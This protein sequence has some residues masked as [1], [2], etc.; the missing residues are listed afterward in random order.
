SHER[1]RD[2][3]GNR[4]YDGERGER[5]GSPVPDVR[6]Q[7]DEREVVE[8][9]PE[10]RDEL[11]GEEQPEGP[12]TQRCDHGVA[13]WSGIRSRI[14]SNTPISPSIVC[15]ALT[16]RSVSCSGPSGSRSSVSRNSSRWWMSSI[17]WRAS[18]RN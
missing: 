4:D 2:G 13:A 1:R 18:E 10:V 17:A 14:S 15:S 12:V 7:D 11:A 16:P 8:P 3:P 5:A 9:V 6:D